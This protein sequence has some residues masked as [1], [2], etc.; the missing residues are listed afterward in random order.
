[1]T[2]PMYI[3]LTAVTTILAFTAIILVAP[4]IGAFTGLI[5]QCFFPQTTTAFMLW[6]GMNAQFWQLTAILGMLSGYFKPSEPTKD[7]SETLN[8]IK[9]FVKSVDK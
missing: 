4:L 5:L 9:A 7:H 6:T 3:L 1:M 2:S 8:K